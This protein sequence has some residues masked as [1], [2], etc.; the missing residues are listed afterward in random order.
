MK[1][2]ELV[3]VVLAS[4]TAGACGIGIQGSG[5]RTVDTRPLEP[6]TRI[7]AGGRGQL[8]VT[9]EAT[10]GDGAA[11]ELEGDDNIVALI[12]TEVVDG[13]LVIRL[14][15]DR[16]IY[17]TIPLR[18]R[19]STPALTHVR[20]SDSIDVRVSGLAG[21]GLVVESSGSSDVT[22]AGD[23][24]WLE[25]HGE[26]SA[27]VFARQLRA[28]DALVTASDTSD[29]EVCATGMLTIEASGSSDV[30]YFCSPASVERH[31]SG[32]ADVTGQ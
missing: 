16:P 19:V 22:L 3:L 11:I 25:L 8:A 12:S 2:L 27:D 10:A 6:F 9:I 24:A 1:R 5:L 23:L 21:D 26:D 17:D 20:S 14:E 28:I 32:S 13:E 4:V 30:M 15:T 18:L 29:I 7:D 31:V